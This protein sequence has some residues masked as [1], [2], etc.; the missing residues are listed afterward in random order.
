MSVMSISASMPRDVD[1]PLTM[2]ALRWSAIGTTLLHRPAPERWRGHNRPD[3]ARML[4]RQRGEE[5]VARAVGAAPPQ[6]PSPSPAI[7][8]AKTTGRTAFV[9]LHLLHGSRHVGLIAHSALRREAH[10]ILS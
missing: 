7:P 1:G 10:T 3:M 8:G 9:A 5:D 2:A 4:T 6:R